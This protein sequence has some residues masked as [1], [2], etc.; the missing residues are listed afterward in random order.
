MQEAGCWGEERG[1][2]PGTSMPSGR[3]RQERAGSLPLLSDLWPEASLQ[4]GIFAHSLEELSQP[5]LLPKQRCPSVDKASAMEAATAQLQVS[6]TEA[7]QMA[8]LFCEL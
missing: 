4:D 1:Q 2:A 3:W 7:M 5:K 6:V 8:V